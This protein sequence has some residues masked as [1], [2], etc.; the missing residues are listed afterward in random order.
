MRFQDKMRSAGR[1]DSVEEAAQV[2]DRIGRVLGRSLNFPEDSELEL[3]KDF[4]LPDWIP[5]N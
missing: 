1:F 3:A 2:F 5:S 4:E